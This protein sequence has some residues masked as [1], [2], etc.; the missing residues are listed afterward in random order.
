MVRARLVIVGSGGF[1]REVATLVED[2]NR[3][4]PTFEIC[5]FVNTDVDDPP[6]GEID[7]YPLLTR[8]QFFGDL[9]GRFGE[10]LNIV[11]GV[12][13][14]AA[15]RKIVTDLKERRSDLIWPNLIHPSV[16]ISPRVRLLGEGIVITAG[17]ILTTNIE[18]ESFAMIN[19]Q[20]TIGHDST[21]KRYS[22]ISP[23]VC[24]SGGVCIGE[25]T[26]VGTGAKIIEQKRIG[27][28]SVIGAGAVVTTDIPD[29]VTA[30]GVPARVITR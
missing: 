28:W 10:R 26:T 1:G 12:G 14:P 7:G 23:G 15:K 29:G 24:V 30:V 6:G 2:I 22:V 9:A 18:I 16:I 5:G 20:C 8:A 21:I 25:G 3:N 4:A 19:L 17:N 27:A 13:F 11:L